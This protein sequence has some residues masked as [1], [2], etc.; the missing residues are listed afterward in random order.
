M[1]G[2]F[3]ERPSLTAN[4][5]FE[6]MISLLHAAGYGCEADLVV[7]KINISKEIPLNIYEYKTRL[8]KIQNSG[9]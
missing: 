6:Y 7:Y 9:Y 4:Y 1:T 5:N 2:G 3:N 8:C